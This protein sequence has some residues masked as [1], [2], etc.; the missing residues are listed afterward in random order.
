VA[1]TV[2]RRRQQFPQK[3]NACIV[4]QVFSVTLTFRDLLL[5]MHCKLEEILNGD[6][7]WLRNHMQILG[8]FQFLPLHIR[9]FSVQLISASSLLA[10]DGMLEVQVL[11]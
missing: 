11:I 10:R 8:A 2:F 9:E 6:S 4:I 7:N 1:I 5:F 3:T